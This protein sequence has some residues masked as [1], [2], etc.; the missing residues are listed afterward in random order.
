VFAAEA[1]G[2]WNGTLGGFRDS[3]VAL[4]LGCGKVFS[5]ML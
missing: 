4:F 1:G 5:L 3:L 2:M